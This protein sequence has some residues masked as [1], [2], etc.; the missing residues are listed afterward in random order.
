MASKCISE[1]TK[2]RSRN[3]SRNLL[4]HGLHVRLSLLD[5]ILQV[6]LGTRSITASKYIFKGRWRVYGYTGRGNQG[7]ESEG[8]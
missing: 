7:G 6:H 2:S 5:L 1:F 3:A 4:D 8:K